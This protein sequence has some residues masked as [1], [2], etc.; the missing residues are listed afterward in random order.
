MAILTTDTFDATT[1]DPS[2]VEFGKTG[3]EASASHYALEDIDLN[4][5]TD[6]IL[7][8]STQDTGIACGDTVA[9]LTGET[10]SQEIIEGSDFILTVACQ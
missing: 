7:H 3:T 1:V 2:T 9:L 4:G 8:F 10:L 5:D 6:L